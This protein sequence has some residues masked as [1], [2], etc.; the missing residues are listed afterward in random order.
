MPNLRSGGAGKPIQLR[1]HRLGDPPR[2]GANLLQQWPHHP[3]V[4]IEQRPQQMNRL[5]FRVIAL[6]GHFLSTLHRF[7]SLDCEFI[8]SHETFPRR[9]I[10]R[11]TL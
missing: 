2:I 4:F 10:P 7:L 11:P 9:T 8:E 1:I 5:N 6:L 3:F